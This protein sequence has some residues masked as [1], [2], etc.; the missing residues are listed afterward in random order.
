[1]SWNKAE[2]ILL[3]TLSVVCRFEVVVVIYLYLYP[4]T[5]LPLKR[6]FVGLQG[7]GRAMLRANGRVGP[8]ESG[9]LEHMTSEWC[10]VL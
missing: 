2:L 9:S 5:R 6:P 10:L 4:A 1:M 3:S 8:R 7:N